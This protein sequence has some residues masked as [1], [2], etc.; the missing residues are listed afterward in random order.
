MAWEWLSAIFGGDKALKLSFDRR[1]DAG[2]DLQTSANRDKRVD[3]SKQKTI[4]KRKSK[5]AYHGE[6][7]HAG[8]NYTVIN[9]D[10][11]YDI[12]VTLD[13]NG[14]IPADALPMLS[15]LTEQF[16]R[17]Q[18]AFVAEDQKKTVN[19]IRSF[20]D[21]PEVRGLLKFFKKRMKL[22]DFT[23]MRTGLYLK[24]LNDTDRHDEAKRYW[25]QV[26]GVMSQR[27]RRIVELASTGYFS[28]FFRPL[29]KQFMKANSD[30]AE[31]R[32][33]KEFEA[34]LEDMR[35]AIFVS[36][37]MSI[38]EIVDTVINKTVKNIKYGSNAEV[39]SLHAAGIY[40]VQKVEQAVVVLRDLFP[41]LSVINGPK[42]AT[43]LRVDIE[44]R[45]NNLDEDLFRDD[46]LV[47]DLPLPS[48]DDVS[49]PVH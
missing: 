4:T 17:K 10:V 33:A 32:F 29:Y 5:D 27:D 49:T 43:I 3:K 36:T 34:I 19:D 48:V 46:A 18:L 21:T 25:R 15:K 8:G 37:G 42:N 20:E 41:A 9:G 24:H 28:S 12:H 35:F 45:K 16:E 47:T 11:N 1:N 14:N 40:Q 13:E 6:V 44:Y 38:E 2:R 7:V 30:T 26:T 23:R 31:R 39:L 22:T